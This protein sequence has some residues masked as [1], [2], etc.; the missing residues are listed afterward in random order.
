MLAPKYASSLMLDD[1]KAS[2]LSAPQVQEIVIDYTDCLK[3][4]PFRES[5]NSFT[6][7]QDF[8]IPSDKYY[9][10]FKSSTDSG[11]VPTWLWSNQTALYND[12]IKIPTCSVQFQIPDTLKSPVFFYYR[13]TDFFQNHRRYVKSLD[14]NQLAGTAVPA[15]T[16][17]GGSCDPLRLD[18]SGKPYYPCGL[19]ANSIFNDTFSQPLGLS[20]A[21]ASSSNFTYAMTTKGIA[22]SSDAK[23]YGKTQYKP[24]DIAVPPNWVNRFPN[25]TY[26][27]ENLPN[28]NTDEAFQ[29]W[30][31][32]AG[33]PTFDKLAMRN[34]NDDMQIGRYQ[35]D[36][37]MSA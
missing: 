12:S 24:E 19:I 28:L 36:I 2:S 27:A 21:N 23:L 6:G 1:S 4:A 3:T 7:D 30:M 11:A 34:D 32:T 26:T 35:V 25:Q 8:L 33:L 29:V 22:W 16:I 14:T 9:S 5:N 10:Y 17:S 13:L 20:V 15:S 37:Q 31:R 18:P